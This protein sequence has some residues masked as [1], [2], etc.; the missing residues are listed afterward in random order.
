VKN[1]LK[2][3]KINPEMKIYV[4]YRD[5]R[6]YGLMENAYGDAADQ[7]VMFIRYHEA[8]KPEVE[9]K[10]GDNGLQVWVTEPTLGKKLMLEA[11]LVSL[12]AATVP[13]EH[14]HSLSQALKVPLNP[15]GFFMEAH[16]KLRP[17]DFPTDGIFM[18]G[19]AHNPKHISESV[20]QGYAA[21][22]RAMTVL[23]QEE[24][25]GEGAI[26]QVNETRC[27]GCSVCEEVCPFHAVE[28]SSETGVAVVNSAL[29][30]GCGLCA[31]SCR[32]G[33]LDVM[34]NNEE[35]VFSL[36]LAVGG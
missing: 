18:C 3:K 27:T 35:Q 23:S 8:D 21:A 28:V 24:M 31:A 16:M 36:L 6:T 14:N 15:D 26:A 19:L 12:A 17:V 22:S 13:N 34:G 25:W 10:E 9:A 30:K 20:A 7:G 11:D 33:A 4:L 2:L 1:A 5:M 29:C 32:S